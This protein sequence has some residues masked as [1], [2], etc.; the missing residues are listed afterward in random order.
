MFKRGGMGYSAQGTGI[1]SGLDTPRRGLV[2]HPGGYAGK[3]LEELAI[4]K[5]EI[6]A[7]KKG[8]WLSDVIGSFGAY[9]N[10]YKEDGP[11]K[12]IGE[13]GYA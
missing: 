9:G 10:P 5:E 6:F 11:A 4:E 2:Q 13:K 7:P 12:T 1:T 8:E 3:T